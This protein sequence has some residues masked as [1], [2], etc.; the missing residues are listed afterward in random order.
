MG[1]YGTFEMVARYPGL[2]EAAVAISGDGDEEEVASM[3]K[4][5]WQIFA[6]QK[7]E[8]VPSIKTKKIA[9]ALLTAGASVSFTLYP[10]W[11]WNKE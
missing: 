1:A 7:D 4:S 5:R 2:F 3:A 6:G 8:V 10:E 9:E 11:M